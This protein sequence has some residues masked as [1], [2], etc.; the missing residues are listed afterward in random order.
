MT[1]L[2]KPVSFIRS[3][4]SL[5]ELREILQ[6]ARSVSA[7]AQALGIK[8]DR[9]I[10]YC[11]RT[12]D[13]ELR[14][15]YRSCVERG[16][17][18]EPELSPRFTVLMWLPV[19]DEKTGAVTWEWLPIWKVDANDEDDAMDIALRATGRDVRDLKTVKEERKR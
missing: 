5:A 17:R 18:R 6:S 19:Y 8:R 3:T 2:P 12:T 16:K 1:A 11:T 4:P 14:S 7:A 13:P 9:L 10:D 15:L